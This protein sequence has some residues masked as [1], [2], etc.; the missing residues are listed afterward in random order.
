[1]RSLKISWSI[2]SLR[3]QCISKDEYTPKSLKDLL[4]YLREL[5]IHIQRVKHTEVVEGS[6]DL[7]T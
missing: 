2:S 3:L 6:P 4:V 5:S 7:F 1:M